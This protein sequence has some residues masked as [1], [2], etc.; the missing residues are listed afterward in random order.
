[1]QETRVEAPAARRETPRWVGWTLIAGGV[2]LLGWAWF[3]AGFLS[4]PSAVGRSRLVLDWFIGSS[5]GAA[6]AGAVS[7][8]GLLR[9]KS[10]A[11]GAAVFS[12]AVMVLT[13]AGVVIGVPVL[14]GLLSTRRSS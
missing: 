11:W 2:L 5:I 4:E 10:W 14:A 9:Q 3:I 6:I 1:M 8:A 13:C 12:A 7:A